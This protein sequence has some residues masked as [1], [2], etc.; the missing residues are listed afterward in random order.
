MQFSF[1]RD[2]V[3]FNL[4][5]SMDPQSSTGR[6]EDDFEE[7]RPIGDHAQLS[8]YQRVS[9]EDVLNPRPANPIPIPISSTSAANEFSIGNYVNS[10]I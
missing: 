4:S 1:V 7:N 5:I 8:A 2:R 10:D 6:T 3:S 9:I